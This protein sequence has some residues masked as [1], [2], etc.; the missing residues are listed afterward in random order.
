M[1]D[2]EQYSNALYKLKKE[3]EVEINI[4]IPVTSNAFLQCINL[5]EMIDKTSS[6]P[7]KFEKTR[8]IFPHVTLKMG[9]VKQNHFINLLIKLEEYFRDI[10][11]FELFPR[12][13]ILKKPANK[14]Y[15]SEIESNELIKISNDLDEILKEDML[16]PRY[17]LSKENLHHITLGYK[18]PECDKISSV[19]GE[20]IQPF[21]VDRIQVSIMGKYG[22]CIGVIKTYQLKL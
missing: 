19:I 15:F 18:Y 4:N 7:I 10:K 8:L 6:T 14:Y 12:P 16:P 2:I 13:V 1:I 5:N 17:A 11:T 21:N 9:T 3:N 20:N 22:V